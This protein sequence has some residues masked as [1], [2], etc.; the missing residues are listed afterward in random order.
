[1]QNVFCEIYK[2]QC[3]V[4]LLIPGEGSTPEA[5]IIKEIPTQRFF[6]G[7]AESLEF[8]VVHY[9]HSRDGVTARLAG[10]G[11]SDQLRYILAV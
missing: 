3:C 1:M 4:Q 11:S 6:F 2:K 9:H 5:I 8:V 10:G 7:I